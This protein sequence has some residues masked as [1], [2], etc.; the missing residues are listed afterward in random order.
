VEGALVAASVRE[1]ITAGA[2]LPSIAKLLQVRDVVVRFG[3]ILALDGVSFE[4]AHGQICGLIG[5]NGSGKTTLFNCISGIYRLGRGD[6]AFDGHSLPPLPRHRRAALGIGRTFQNV[7]L[8]PTMSVSDN[9]LVGAHALG[10]SGFLAHA[11]RLPP[12]RREEAEA[13]QKLAMLLALLGLEEVARVPV[14]RL[15]FGTRKRVELAR[16]LI[17]GPKLLLLDEPAGGLNHEE[18][19]DLARLLQEIRRHFALGMLLVEHHMGLVMR[20]SERVVALEFGRKIADGTPE[21]VQAD[22]EVVRA[23]LGADPGAGPGG[24][25]HVVPA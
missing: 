23:Y 18:V 9:V 20:V 3:G 6:I 21:E 12:V 10:R 2:P 19:A 15:A 14:A 22:P 11:L 1:P 25:G 4:V 13:R 8:F 5:P 24:V 16:A 17:G 7:A